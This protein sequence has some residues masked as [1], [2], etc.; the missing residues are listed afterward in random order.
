MKFLPLKTI[1]IFGVSKF[2]QIHA[3]GTKEF[4]LI[5]EFSCIHEY[6]IKK[7]SLIRKSPFLH[8]NY[9][10]GNV[11]TIKNRIFATIQSTLHILDFSIPLTRLKI[12]KKPISNIIRYKNNIFL[13]SLLEQ[14]G[15][16]IDA[17]TLC[18]LKTLKPQSKI[19]FLSESKVSLNNNLIIFYT[20]HGSLEIW[21]L[22]IFQN[23]CSLKIN[24][25]YNTNDLFFTNNRES[26]FINFQKRN[27][28]I[29]DLKKKYRNGIYKS[30]KFEKFKKFFFLKNQPEINLI[31][32]KDHLIW[33]K[34][35]EKI[36]FESFLQGHNGKINFI[37]LVK[38]NTFLTIGSYD[39]TIGIHYFNKK[40]MTFDLIK[41]KS[42]RNVPF[43][44]NLNLGF[45]KNLPMFFTKLKKINAFDS[46]KINKKHF[47][48]PSKNTKIKKEYKA[49]NQFD[50]RQNNIV[51]KQVIVKKDP[52][53]TDKYKFAILYFRNSKIWLCDIF[54]NPKDVRFSKYIQNEKNLSFIFCLSISTKLDI[55]IIGYEDNFI[56]L[57]DIGSQKFLFHGKNHNF[58]DL[59]FRCKIKFCEMDFSEILFLSYCSHGILNLWNLITLKI[60]KTLII[61]GI[62]LL[63]W[64]N[65]RDL[66]TA[67]LFNYKIYI[68]I[69]QKFFNIRVLE[70]HHAKINGLLF[71]KKDRFLISFS[72]DKTV[73][74]WDLIEN[75]CCDIIKFKYIP[76]NIE[77][78][79]EENSFYF[80]HENTIGYGKWVL[81]SK[82]T[83]INT[84]LDFLPLKKFMEI[85]TN[86]ILSRINSKFPKKIKNLNFNYNSLK[87]SKIKNNF[88]LKNF[89]FPKKHNLTSIS[90]NITQ[91][92][93][94]KSIQKKLSKILE[95]ILILLNSKLQKKDIFLNKYS[96]NILMLSE[97]FFFFLF[98]ITE[99]FSEII[100]WKNL[101]FDFFLFF[102]PTFLP[103]FRNIPEQNFSA[104]IY[105]KL[106]IDIINII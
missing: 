45:D 50:G 88:R 42:G 14:K 80:G 69:P 33:I 87:K 49:K 89:K 104:I 82:I 71:I 16:I 28:L 75:K 84:S 102:F 3:K 6:E 37:E 103:I 46:L 54:T 1:G 30:E 83:K 74:L 39:N 61:K 21:N 68:I 55:G 56:S 26:L 38:N 18:S 25:P 77:I 17:L 5:S 95:S 36:I 4:V 66:I 78:G 43:Y 85:E 7:L 90:A 92:K 106:L 63:T 31:F 29:C 67:S 70:S 32:C 58:F 96:K 13:F 53:D 48:H 81:N 35:D 73:K 27:L 23:I 72:F 40:R 59:K 8:Y 15:Y 105:D 99:N 62:E 19:L 79:K 93:G 22:D 9:F 64:S 60:E 52:I 44:Q 24:L 12:F 47:L 51:L 57:V 98:L 86:F 76:L 65:T 100:I 41:K 20:N 91:I 94:N 34:R 11:L 2:H 10:I 97:S 101:N